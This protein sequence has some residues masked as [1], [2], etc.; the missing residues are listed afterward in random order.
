MGVEPQLF[1]GHRVERGL[2]ISDQVL[3]DALGVLM[4]DAL[5]RV[6]RC[7]FGVLLVRVVDQLTPFNGEKVFVALTLR[8][9]R[10]VLAGGHREGARKETGDSAQE[11]NRRGA[12]PGKQCAFWDD[13]CLL[14]GLRSDMTT[15]P[16][17]VRFL[18]RLREDL[19]NRARPFLVN[20]PGFD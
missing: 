7:Q 1:K 13:S 19:E 14:T 17:L 18:L 10:D 3:C 16:V 6:D 5:G 4:R 12:L 2:W 8:S 9:H 15:N 11:N 20:A